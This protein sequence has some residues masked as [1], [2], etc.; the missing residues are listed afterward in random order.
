MGE[1]PKNATEVLR[2]LQA[3]DSP[4]TFTDI[5]RKCILSKATVSKY[6]HQLVEL[7][8]VKKVHD[9]NSKRWK[10]QTT[11]KAHSLNL[12]PKQQAQ[13]RMIEFLYSVNVPDTIIWQLTSLISYNLN[14]FLELPQ[15]NDCYLAF[16]YVYYNLLTGNLFLRRDR[17]CEF[18]RIKRIS[19]DYHLDKILSNKLG[20]YHIEYMG[21]DFFFHKTDEIGTNL[22]QI[23]E[24]LLSQYILKQTYLAS[25]QNAARSWEPLPLEDI[26]KSIKSQLKEKN[27]IKGRIVAPFETFILK[28]VVKKA[29]DRGIPNDALPESK[30]EEI[31][32]APEHIEDIVGYCPT[33]GN[34]IFQGVLKCSRCKLEIKEKDLLFNI[35]QAQELSR[36]YMGE[37]NE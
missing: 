24:D 18:C 34:W 29:V 11:Q 14:A 1:V 7:Q 17:F 2:I 19:L 22:S 25:Q 15:T 6:L 35:I 36:K 21:A 33:C 10:Y 28:Y 12:V 3:S 4:V 32:F 23:T 13:N 30:P 27:L 9:K 5:A 31:F 8:I 26:V 37:S 16:F 20:F